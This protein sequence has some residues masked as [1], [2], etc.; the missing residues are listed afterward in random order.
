MSRALNPG[1][2]YIDGVNVLNWS[3][4][5]GASR[6]TFVI[7]D[8][9]NNIVFQTDIKGTSYTL[10]SLQAKLEKNKNYAW[11]VHHSVRREVSTPVPFYIS[12]TDQSDSILKEIKSLVIY[13][14]ADATTQNLFEAAQFHQN[15]FYLSAQQK[16]KDALAKTP[17]NSLAK[18]M[19][20]FFCNEM[21]ETENAAAILV[22]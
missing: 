13:Q 20:S 6:Y 10:N 7:E 8:E 2:A 15:G 11:Y 22:R 5:K 1:G 21:G 16:Y 3:P 18:M 14:Q 19:Y 4:M 12:E 9:S 17:G